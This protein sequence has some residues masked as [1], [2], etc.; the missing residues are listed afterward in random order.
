MSIAESLLTAEEFAD[1]PDDG[2]STELVDGRMIELPPPKPGH[3]KF[4]V[5]VILKLGRFVE[6]HDLGTVLS[7]DSGII[8]RRN[9]DSVRGADVAYFSYDRLPRGPIPDAY[10]E[11]APELILEVRS[12]GDRWRE[13]EKKVA[14][15]LN[16]GTL[17]VCVL[18]PKSRSLRLYEPGQ[19]VKLLGPDDELSFPGFLPGFVA[20]VGSFFD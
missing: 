13:I 17:A 8:T 4:C 3:G 14:E 9:P 1:L 11:V 18:D 16:L 5:R 10:A 12:P 20:V 19:P 2:R 6:D 15:Y 7:N